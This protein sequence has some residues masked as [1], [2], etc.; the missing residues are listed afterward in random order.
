MMAFQPWKAVKAEMYGAT[1]KGSYFGPLSSRLD[2][3][4]P[5]VDAL[6]LQHLDPVEQGLDGLVVEVLGRRPSGDPLRVDPVAVH[7]R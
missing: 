7:V 1:V 3:V 5:D 2:H 6:V 4:H